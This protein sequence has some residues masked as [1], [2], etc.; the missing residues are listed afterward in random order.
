M[1][2]ETKER[3][4]GKT[5]TPATKEAF[6]ALLFFV[7]PMSESGEQIMDRGIAWVGGGGQGSRQQPLKAHRAGA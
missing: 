1:T 6:L 3:E 4:K 5:E 2:C 7:S